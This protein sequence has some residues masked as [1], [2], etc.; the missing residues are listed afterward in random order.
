MPAF[1]E[2]T[3]TANAPKEA[4]WK[5]L[6]DFPNIANYTETVRS[7]HSTS[8]ND[9]EI[10]ATRHCEVGTCRIC[11]RDHYRHQAGRKCRHISVRRRRRS[12]QGIHDNI[13]PPRGRCQYDSAHD[14]RR[15][16][17]QRRN[18]RPH[19]LENPRTTPTRK[20]PNRRQRSRSLRRKNG[21]GETIPA[22][23]VTAVSTSPR[24]ARMRRKSE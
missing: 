12:H 24:E 13:L 22:S 5:I 10:G 4:V 2:A 19:H 15:N 21:I 11:R 6:A 18:L 14:E 8:E 20:S 17:T 1:V 3:V 16:P 7:S 23:T 9:F